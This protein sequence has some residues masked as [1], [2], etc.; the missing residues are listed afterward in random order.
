MRTLFVGALAA[1][2]VGCSCYVSPQTGFEACTGAG[3]NWF[4]CF[5]R[6]AVSQATEP[7]LA[8]V[9]AN[10][11][12]QA[13]RSKPAAKTK[14]PSSVHVRDKAHFATEN[15]GSTASAKQIEPARSDPP[16]EGSD[17]IPAK[18]KITVA[19][20]LEDPAS[21]EFGEMKRAM[22]TNTLEQL[23]DAIC[24]H[25]KGKRASGDGTGDKPFL[26]IL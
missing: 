9:D 19:A 3:G 2:L 22:R 17:P 5:D 13:T 23:A 25:V 1:T 24:G 10:S 20:K 15:A 11:E 18:A 8:S 7:E 16:S 12:E 6:T 26:C 4:A 14:K 21:A